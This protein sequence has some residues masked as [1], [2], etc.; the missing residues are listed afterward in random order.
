M[1]SVFATGAAAVEVRGR[2]LGSPSAKQFQRSPTATST[3]YRQHTTCLCAVAAACRRQDAAQ[4]QHRFKS[5]ENKRHNADC[6]CRWCVSSTRTRLQYLSN[7]TH[8][9]TL[10]S[11][12]TA[13]LIAYELLKS[14]YL[15]S[16]PL[17]AAADALARTKGP[18]VR[19]KREEQ[20]DRQSKS[21]RKG[22][23]HFL[24]V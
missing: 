7:S 23:V 19:E 20:G 11:Q 3:L 5:N 4:Q 21:H 15:P 12:P 6:R 14:R 16:S 8:Q 13:H 24:H 10:A 2:A 9:R 17:G 22:C 1:R 18:M